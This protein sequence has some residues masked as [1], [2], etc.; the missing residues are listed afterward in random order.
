MQKK[1]SD[2]PSDPQWLEKLRRLHP[3]KLFLYVAIV[4][5]FILFAFLAF[6]F[7]LTNNLAQYFLP[8]YFTLSTI[9][10]LMSSLTMSKSLAYY[11]ADNPKLLNRYLIGTFLLGLLFI[12]SQMKGWKELMDMGIY[13]SGSVN[14]SY[15][16]L[17]SA[18]H[19]LHFFGGIIFFLFVYFRAFAANR[20][21][22]K[23]LVYIT[24]P[25]EYMLLDLLS[26]YWHFMDF[27]WMALYLL[28]W[29]FTF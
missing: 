27:I 19:L 4:G 12:G 25:Y 11:K 13:F 23:N 17:L 15:L 2:Y 3:F 26:I 18:L 14:G 28:F 8:N 21:T 1:I 29:V 7:A 22:V 20:D 6:G 10:I 9:F 24:D 16:Y 5:I